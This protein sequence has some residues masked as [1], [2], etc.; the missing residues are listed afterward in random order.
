MKSCELSWQ[1]LMSHQPQL[2]A[3]Q[4]SGNGLSLPRAWGR[5]PCAVENSAKAG[6]A[7]HTGRLRQEQRGSAVQAAGSLQG[8]TVP[9]AQ[10]RPPFPL[11]Q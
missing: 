6:T 8:L 9:P 10:T 2:P 7:S 3:R 11:R 5:S 1:V 4:R